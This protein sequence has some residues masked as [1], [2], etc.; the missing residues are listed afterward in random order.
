MQNTLKHTIGLVGTGLHSGAQVTLTLVP[1]PVDHGIVFVRS[2]LPEGENEIPALWNRVVDT[3]L[4]TV[5][6]NDHGAKVGTIE[7]LMSALAG[8]NIHNLRIEIDAEEVPIMDGSAA[9]FVEAF[10]ATG[11]QPQEAPLRA[12]KILKPVTIEQ[13]GKRI[14]LSPAD[15][16]SYSGQIDFPHPAIGAQDYSI[17]LVNGNFKHEVADCRTFGFESE[18]E[19]LRSVGLARGGSL[20]NAIV[21]GKDSVLNP[22]GLRRADEFIRHKLLDAIGDLYLA[23][24]PIIGAYE[25]IKPGHAMNNAILHALF[26]DDSN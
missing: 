8:L 11:I 9:A 6:A 17:Q 18:I 25:G 15:V 5:I 12:I 19:Y 1:A 13:D 22:G 20:D 10:E 21:L 23:G 4:C 16:T 24:A 3:K 26:A 7:H 2:D 14:T